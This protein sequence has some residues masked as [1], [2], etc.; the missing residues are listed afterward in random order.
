MQADSLTATA[1]LV[2]SRIVRPALYA[3]DAG[4]D[5]WMIVDPTASCHDNFGWN[6]A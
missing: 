2:G 6:G 3:D 4:R 1:L 5:A